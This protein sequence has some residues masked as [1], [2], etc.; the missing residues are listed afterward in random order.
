[1]VQDQVTHAFVTIFSILLRKK[2]FYFTQFFV[3]LIN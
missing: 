1:M 3:I 2:T